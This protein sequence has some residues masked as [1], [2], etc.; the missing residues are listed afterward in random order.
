MSFVPAGQ[1]ASKLNGLHLTVSMGTWE[2]PDWTAWPKTSYEF[3]W[4]LQ[5][6]LLSPEG[7]TGPGGSSSKVVHPCGCW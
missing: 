3:A 5:L 2:Q 6:G 4:S 7:L 1:I